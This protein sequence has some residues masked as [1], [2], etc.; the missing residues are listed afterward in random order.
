MH[1]GDEQIFAK[2]TVEVLKKSKGQQKANSTN[3]V[4]SV[5]ANVKA[6][7]VYQIMPLA[8]QNGAFSFDTVLQNPVLDFLSGYYESFLVLVKLML[9]TVAVSGIF[10]ALMPSE[11]WLCDPFLRPSKYPK[12]TNLLH[13]EFFFKNPSN[14]SLS[15]KICVV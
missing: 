15:Y 8:N 3:V 13:E 2:P 5:P 9:I 4:S 11:Q 6:K 14:K 1:N 10:F 7:I 12:K